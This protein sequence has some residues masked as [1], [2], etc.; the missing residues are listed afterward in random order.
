MQMWAALTVWIAATTDADTRCAMHFAMYAQR[1]C[2]QRLCAALW[3]ERLAFCAGFARVRAAQRCEQNGGRWHGALI[4]CAHGG[5]LCL[6][7]VG[8]QLVCH[9]AA[10]SNTP[11]R[12]E[13]R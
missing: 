12:A 3:V 10:T 7:A 6:C 1:I 9:Y 11:I 8:V 13:Q 4:C 2:L 5:A